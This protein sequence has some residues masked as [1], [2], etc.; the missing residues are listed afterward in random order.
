MK[1][2]FFRSPLHCSRLANDGLLYACDRGNNRVQIFKA[3]EAGKPCSNPE[4]EVGKCGFVG[5]MHVAPQSVG[6]TSGTVNFSTDPN[7][8]YLSNSWRLP[9][10]RVARGRVREGAR[11]I[12]PILT[13]PRKRGKES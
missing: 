3:S 1:P 5:E 2:N 7:G 10:L 11:S 9:P 13:F 8:T 12:T 6:G 4:G